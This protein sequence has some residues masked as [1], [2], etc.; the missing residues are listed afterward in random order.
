MISMEIC[1]IEREILP[2]VDRT[3]AII[4]DA[5]KTLWK[6]RVSEGIGYAYLRREL[7][8]G[9]MGTVYAGVKGIIGIKSAL[10]KDRERPDAEARGLVMFY[11]ALKSAGLGRRH[12]MA[13]Y[14]M[15]YIL[16]NPLA[17]TTALS[18]SVRDDM[19]KFI[20]TMGGSTAANVAAEYHYARPVSNQDMFDKEGKLQGALILMWDGEDK[21]RAVEDMLISERYGFRVRDCTVVG[22][23]RTDIPLMSAAK[24]SIASP[25]ATSE[26]HEIAK[27]FLYEPPYG[28]F[29]SGA[30]AP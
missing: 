18:H 8:R 25:L 11:D 3:K 16:D 1:E 17:S 14:A 23:S 13:A 21:L 10:R 26:V 29:G 6:G 27:L 15:R 2:R 30:K 19:P 20:A 9:H 24:L 4:F 12:E 5:D 28:T 7:L 22:D